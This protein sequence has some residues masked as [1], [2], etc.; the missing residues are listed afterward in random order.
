MTYSFRIRFIRSPTD[1]IQTEALELHV[2]VPGENTSITLKHLTPEQPIKDA[3]QLAMSGHGYSSSQEAMEAGQ[4]YQSALM[5][6][7]ARVR[8]GADF[9]Q[10]AARGV[11]TEHGLKLLEQ[12]VGH[13]VLNSTHGLM[14]F[15]TDPKP[16][17]AAVSVK[18]IRGT[19]ADAFQVLLLEAISKHPRPFRQG[20]TGLLTLQRLV[21]PAKR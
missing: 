2:S 9:G 7:L 19:N 11:Y 12:Q 4:K 17:F 18:A 13:R 1:T 21:L 3:E 14:V 15:A 20:A 5:V 10:R 8:V 6:A 16:R